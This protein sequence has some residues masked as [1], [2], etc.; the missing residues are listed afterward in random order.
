MAGF[1][2]EYGVKDVRRERVV[3]TLVIT[4]VALVA[5]VI[6]GYFILR[7]YPAKR[8]VNAF[9]DDLRNHDYQAAYRV[10]GCAA[11]CRDYPYK[12]F[13]DDWGPKSEFADAAKASV[14]RTRYC[15]SGVIVTLNSPA[16]KEVP[17]WYERSDNTLG[18][19]PWP[20]CAEHIPAPGA[21]Q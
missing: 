7:T 11:P 13:L 1:L 15:N 5:A 17:L 8:Q 2:D 10:W 12:S 9:L 21:P 6:A 14:K 19:A 18:F 20:V 3:K 16:G 4:V